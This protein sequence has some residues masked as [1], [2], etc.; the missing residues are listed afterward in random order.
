MREVVIASAVRTALGSFGGSLKDVPAVDLGA[1][2]IKEALNKAGVKPEC[3]DE[4]LMGN[5]IQAGLGQNP[6]RQAAV[7]AG[8]PVE[9]PSMTI[10]KVCGSGLRCV[11]LAAQMI[12]A[13]DADVIVAGGMENMSQGPYVLRTARFGQRMGDGKMVDA[14]VNDALTDAFNGYHMGITAENIAEQWGLTRE[15]QDEF[16]ANSQMKTEAAIKAGKF[17]DEIVPVVIPQRKGDPIVFDTDE[18]PRFGTTAEK[19]AKLRPAFKKDGTVTAGNA[20]GINDGAAALVVMSAEKAKELG[21]TPICKIVSYGSKGL[22]PSIMGYGPFYATKKAL[23]GTGLTV[24]DLDLIEANE[25]FAAQ[26]LAVAKDL[27]FDMSKVNV[28][29]GAIALGHPVGASGARILVTLLHEMMK[30]DAKRGL[31]T[32]CIGGGMGTALIVER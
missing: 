17:K 6:A 8:L 18:F 31:A 2:V 26:S 28:N 7:K 11:A 23:E 24:A 3:V 29:G 15:M 13:G 4:V 14:M 10:N 27:E 1:L 30:R 9:I 20:S 32:L 21:V 19:L 22:D 25:A 12:K 5:V 16:A